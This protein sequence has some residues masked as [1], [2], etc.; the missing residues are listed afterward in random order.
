M[1]QKVKPVCS[2]ISYT[3]IDTAVVLQ[4]GNVFIPMILSVPMTQY[5][6]QSCSQT[7]HR[8]GVETLPRVSLL[9]PQT[10]DGFVLLCWDHLS[11]VRPLAVALQVVF[12][13]PANQFQISLL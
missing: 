8:R 6:T 10:C 13:A 2:L 1:I 12:L 3:N 5:H 9:V 4:G 7:C 11:W